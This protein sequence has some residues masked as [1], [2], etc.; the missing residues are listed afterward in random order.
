ML[1][2]NKANEKGFN[3]ILFTPSDSEIA[4]YSPFKRLPGSFGWQYGRFHYFAANQIKSVELLV[5][6]NGISTLSWRRHQYLL[7]SYSPHA[8]RIGYCR[9]HFCAR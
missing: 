8:G 7:F 1:Q 2:K 4:F 3:N 5:T 9:Y 6:Y